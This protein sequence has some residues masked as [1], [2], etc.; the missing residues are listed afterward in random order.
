VHREMMGRNQE[1]EVPSQA[2]LKVPVKGARDIGDRSAGL[3]HQVKVLLVREVVDGWP[4]PEVSVLDDALALEGVQSPVHGRRGDL[5]ML[6]VDAPGE[7]LGRHVAGSLEQRSN[8]GSALNGG[9]AAL[10][11]QRSQDLVKLGGAHGSRLY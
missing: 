1:V 3:A 2:L 6:T 5:G 7:L 9:P 4:M 8:H 10:R 11:S